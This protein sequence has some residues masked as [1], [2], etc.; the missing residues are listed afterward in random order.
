MQH[1]KEYNLNRIDV[2]GIKHLLGVLYISNGS[3]CHV[4]LNEPAPALSGVNSDYH[5]DG[6]LP[7]FLDDLRLDGFIGNI[8][9]KPFVHSGFP[10]SPSNWSHHH[11]LE[12]LLNNNDLKG[13]L[14]IGDYGNHDVHH[15]SLNDYPRLANMSMHGDCF[16]I[17]PVNGEQPKFTGY[18]NGFGHLI[19]KFAKSDGSEIGNRVSDLLKCE[20]IANETLKHFNIP[21]SDS[22]IYEDGGY[23]FLENQRFDRAGLHGRLSMM[24][25]CSIDS[26]YVGLLNSWSDTANNLYNDGLISQKTESLIHLIEQFGHAIGNSDMHQGN[27]SMK[28]SDDGATFEMLPV[29]DM[30]PM[31]LMPKANI[32][33]ETVILKCDKPTHKMACKYWCDVIDGDVSDNMKKIADDALNKIE[34]IS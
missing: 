6:S 9:A 17:S 29:Y 7:F 12:Y 11:I 25:V 1:G 30:L 8:L 26:E 19:V 27:M 24:S 13:D 18:R 15:I 20:H 16:G 33:P 23:V 14:V 34:V 10:G 31:C 3:G 2:N 21:S 5:Y 22:S 4:T 28:L 32:I